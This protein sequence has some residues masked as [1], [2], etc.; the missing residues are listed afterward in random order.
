MAH[1]ISRFDFSILTDLFWEAVPW[2]LADVSEL[3]LVFIAATLMLAIAHHQGLQATKEWLQYFRNYKWPFFA[4][5]SYLIVRAHYQLMSRAKMRIMEMEELQ[6]DK[7]TLQQ[8]KTLL[9]RYAAHIKR[10]NG[11]SNHPHD[12]SGNRAWYLF[13]RKLLSAAI[14]PE[15]KFAWC[16]AFNEHIFASIAPER[17]PILEWFEMRD[18][19][20]SQPG[21][22]RKLTQQILVDGQCSICQTFWIYAHLLRGLEED[23]TSEDLLD[24]FHPDDFKKDLDTLII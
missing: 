17:K 6:G 16:G 7:T 11:D 21:G 24:K 13:G 23:V 1:K 20:N 15:T 2:G 3:F 4:S 5:L 12:I 14:K 18:S 8:F 10:L 9:M 22:E 19:I